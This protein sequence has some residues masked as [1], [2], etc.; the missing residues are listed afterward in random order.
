MRRRRGA[1]GR[2]PARLGFLQA[3]IGR[4][5]PAPRAATGARRMSEAKIATGSQIGR[6]LPR[7]EARAKVTGRAEYIHNLRLPGML[8][9]KIAR[10]TIPH[11]RIH[12]IDTSAAKAMPGVHS[13]VIGEDILTVI[14]D[15]YFGPA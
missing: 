11:A 10:S 2:R 5:A 6:S 13:V 12:G 14:P 1:G 9:A 15:P 7:V 3:G 8:H 4:G